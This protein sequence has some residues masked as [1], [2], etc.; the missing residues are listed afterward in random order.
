MIA[1]CGFKNKEIGDRIQNPGEKQ[2]KFSLYLD[3]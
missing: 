1:D 2:S 3:V